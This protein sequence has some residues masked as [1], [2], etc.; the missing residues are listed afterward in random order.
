[1]GATLKFE[2]EIKHITSKAYPLTLS[3]SYLTDSLIY[4]LLIVW[5]KPIS[6][7][8]NCS[9]PSKYACYNIVVLLFLSFF[10]LIYNMWNNNISKFRQTCAFV[11]HGYVENRRLYNTESGVF[12]IQFTVFD[13]LCYQARVVALL[14][15]C[16]GAQSYSSIQLWA[17]TFRIANLRKS[18]IDTIWPSVLTL[19]QKKPRLTFVILTISLSNLSTNITCWNLTPLRQKLCHDRKSAI[20][21]CSTGSLYELRH[22]FVE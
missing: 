9:V 11:I 18:A 22:L 15:K 5:G 10:V 2:A 14:W 6:N 13:G 3:V 17:Q 1:M 4:S 8:Y 7:Y 19:L 12:R 16:L 20:S 21:H